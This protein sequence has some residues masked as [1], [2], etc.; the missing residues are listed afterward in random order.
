MEDIDGTIAFLLASNEPVPARMPNLD[1]IAPG[2]FAVA[3]SQ[4]MPLAAR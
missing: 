3:N 4:P 2:L 1:E